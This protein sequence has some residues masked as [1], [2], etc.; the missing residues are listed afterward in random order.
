VEDFM[1][2]GSLG[3]SAVSALLS[4][5]T[6]TQATTSATSAPAD[7]FGGCSHAPSAPSQGGSNALTGSTKASLSDEILALLTQLQQQAGSTPPGA[8]S[9]TTVSA[10]SA[11]TTI[12]TSGSASDP[13]SQLFSAMDSDGDGT[14]SQGEMETYIQSKGG[15]AAQADAL[16]SGLNQSGSGNLTQAQLASDLQQAGGAGGVGGAHRHHRHHHAPS[17]DQVG[18]DLVGA[19]DSDGSGSVDLAEFETFVT[20]L[21]GT[22]NQADS[23]FAALDPNGTGSVTASQFA[24]ALTALQSANPSGGSPVLSLLD[25][26]KSTLSATTSSVNVTA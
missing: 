19:M 15:T 5:L 1:S 24:S 18:N 6:S 8:G 9:S 2:I 4:Q 17:A 22:T 16:F 23:D 7:E 20:G 11:S 26:F 14:I 12:G 13:L 3:A 25:A 21:G 10:I